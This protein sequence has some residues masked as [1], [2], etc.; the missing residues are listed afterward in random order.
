MDLK[1]RVR[2]TKEELNEKGGKKR[3]KDAKKKEKKKTGERHVSEQRKKQGKE[4]V[5]TLQC[6]IF[7]IHMPQP[8]KTWNASLLEFLIY[9]RDYRL[10][11]HL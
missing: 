3:R 6:R 2:K 1:I 7:L 10:T 8:R 11:F 4:V 9:S 5:K